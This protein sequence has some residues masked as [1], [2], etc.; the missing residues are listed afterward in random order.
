MYDKKYAEP[1]PTFGK[2]ALRFTSGSFAFS[3]LQLHDIN[4]RFLL[5][6]RTE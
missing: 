5:A 6:F 1:A 4:N 3:H 2:Q